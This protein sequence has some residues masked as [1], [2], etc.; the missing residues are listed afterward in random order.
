MKID[1]ENIKNKLNP[2]NINK[3][4]FLFLEKRNRWIIFGCSILMLGYCVFLWYAF[5][6]NHQWTQER[7]QEYI[8]SKEK[9]TVFRKN[10]FDDII[11]EKNSRDG[12]YQESIGSVPDIFRIKNN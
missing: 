11:S 5:V 3:S 8:K 7:K 2:A 6:Y 1:L 9:E 12:R 4:F 10:K